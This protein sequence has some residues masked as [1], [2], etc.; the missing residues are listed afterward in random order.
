MWTRPSLQVE[1]HGIIAADKDQVTSFRTYQRDC[2]K[3]ELA[4]PSATISPCRNIPR[5][6]FHTLIDSR[7]VDLVVHGPLQNREVS[8]VC[9]FSV[10]RAYDCCYFL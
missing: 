9:I 5:Q 1:E 10:N 2:Q 7:F 3:T 8:C 4:G 6:Q